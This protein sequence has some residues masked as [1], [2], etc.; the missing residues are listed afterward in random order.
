M[1]KRLEASRDA[2]DLKRGS[3]GLVDVEFA[4]QLVQLRHGGR[5]PS[6]LEPNIW[7]A[8]AAIAGAG[9]WGTPRIAVFREGYTFLRRIESRLRIVYN[10]ARGELPEDPRDLRKLAVRIGG[11][12][13]PDADRALLAD[14]K[15]HNAA[16]RKEY[17]DVVAEERTS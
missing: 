1:R 11:Y 4:V 13:G 6:I 5:H 10:V 17:L 14:L 2:G 7:K 15:R 12:D 16:I 9:L 3:G 8:L